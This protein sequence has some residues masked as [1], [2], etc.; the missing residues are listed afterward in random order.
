MSLHSLAVLALSGTPSPSAPVQQW[1][2]LSPLPGENDTSWVGP[3]L[4]GFLSLV[5]LIVAVVVIW[6]SLNK[7]LTKV[8]FDEGE[9]AAPADRAAT[10]SA[11]STAAA[12]SSAG[13]TVGDTPPPTSRE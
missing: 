10:S 4:F 5:F 8:T 3:G 2:P 9:P 6:K 1:D 12:P 11:T 7:Q 13:G